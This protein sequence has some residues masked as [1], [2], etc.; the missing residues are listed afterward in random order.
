MSGIKASLTMR[1]RHTAQHFA[2]RDLRE[3]GSEGGRE[4]G[5]EGRMRSVVALRR[6]GGREGGMVSTHP[7]SQY[8]VHHALH[9]R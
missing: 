1:T 2:S 3:A 5:R 7:V 8:N 4:G 6:E 9:R